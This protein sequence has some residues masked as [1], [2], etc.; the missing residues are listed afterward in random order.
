MAINCANYSVI[1]LPLP[2]DVSELADLALKAQQIA[3]YEV[4]PLANII[5]AHKR[6]AY[7]I[8]GNGWH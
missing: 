5:Q 4:W 2:G 6:V 1:T 8:K 3:L 7:S